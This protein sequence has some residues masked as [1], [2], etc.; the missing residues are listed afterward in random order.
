[1]NPPPWEVGGLRVLFYSSID[2]RYHFTGAC[3]HII[4][5]AAWGPAARLA[6]CQYEG[7][8][9]FYLLSCDAEW[10]GGTDTWHES[11]EAAMNQAEFEYKGVSQT[12]Q[13]PT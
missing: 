8:P 10:Y 11:I 1:V 13:R 7:D 9:G 6:I 12:W 4:G 3:D 5:G 2:Q